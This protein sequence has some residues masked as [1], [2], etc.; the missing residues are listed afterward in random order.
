MADYEVIQTRTISGKG[1]LKIPVDKKKNRAFTLS[2][3]VIRP[4]KNSYQNFNYNPPRAKF[5]FLTFLR[6]GY[7]ISQTS[8]EYKKQ[9][10]DGVNDFSGQ[11]LLALKC[12][13]NAILQSIYN[14]SVALAATPGG[15]GLTPISFTNVIAEYENL[16]LSWDECRLVCY[17]DTAI[18]LKLYRLKYDVCNN[19]F[20]DDQPPPPPPPPD[21]PEVPP[22]TDIEVDPP[23]DSDT[24]DD[25]NT[26]PYPD[27][28]IDVCA[29]VG[30]WRLD[31]DATPGGAQVFYIKGKEDDTFEL[32][33]ES[34]SGCLDGQGQNLYSAGVKVLDG[35][36]CTS[37][38]VLT[39]NEF[40]DSAPSGVTPNPN[41]RYPA[42]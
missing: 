14:L 18:E 31:Y 34:R 36:T 41:P 28:A 35:F 13:N 40:F 3:T 12:V 30:V 15:A 7:V 17:A 29:D 6:E 33:L 21:T 27:D 2:S 20:D 4:P 19:D 5:G 22:G 10:F 25:G 8:I 32:I 37:R 26:E 16:R 39:T 11:T 1:V 24:S 23:Y 42:C 9:S 38:A